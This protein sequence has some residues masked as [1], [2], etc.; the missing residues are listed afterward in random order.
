MKRF[1]STSSIF[2]GPAVKHLFLQ[3]PNINPKLITSTGKNG[4][5]TKTDFLSYLEKNP[6]SGEKE[7]KNNKINTPLTIKKSNGERYK[8]LPNTSN[9]S[10]KKNEVAHFYVQLECRVDNLKEMK[11][12]KED[13]ITT[14]IVKT[15]QNH[16][17]CNVKKISNNEYQ[18]K[19]EIDIKFDTK[20]KQGV[21]KNAH[22]FGIEQISNTKLLDNTIQDNG[23]IM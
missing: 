18:I 16:P 21:L 1:Y 5:I 7:K 23:T 8:D 11:Y 10:F 12:T 20:D 15:L 3:Y 13:I 19:K 22:R 17:N 4:R 9:L 6:N 2:S 14:M